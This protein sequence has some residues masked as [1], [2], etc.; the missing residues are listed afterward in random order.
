[1]IFIPM[2][3]QVAPQTRNSRELGRRVEQV[4]RDFQ[5]DHPELTDAEIRT[6]L[7]QSVAT[8]D[9]PETTGRNRRIAV[10]STAAALG[11]AGAILASTQS[12][13]GGTASGEWKWVSVV[14]AII[15]I[16]LAVIR[17]V[18]RARD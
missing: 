6:A 12:S 18:G 14:V 10:V 5:R 13:G 7:A 2:Q 1:M 11:I 17:V 3:Q 8:T 9:D 4:V 15:V 16:A